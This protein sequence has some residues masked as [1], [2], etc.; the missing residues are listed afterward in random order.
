MGMSEA[1]AK[2]Q[3]AEPRAYGEGIAGFRLLELVVDRRV[4]IPRPE[5]EGLVEQVLTWAGGRWGK[6][7]GERGKGEAGTV[8]DLGTG[9]GCIALSLATEGRFARIVATDVSE[10]ALAVARLNADRVR[11][12]PMPEFRQGPFFE[13]VVGER[14]DVIVTNPPYIAEPE[15]DGLDRSVRDYEPAVALLSGPDGLA[16]TR[17]I[18]ER[19]A[20]YLAPGG[21]LAMEVDS[22]RAEDSAALARAAGF[23][24]VRL[25]SDVF[26]RLRYLLVR[27]EPA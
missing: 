5:T 26:D 14:F 22:R 13:P 4:L 3:A 8:L 21:L 12:E 27:K 23:A 6:G 15:Y 17:T 19:A 2:Q 24:D 7:K 11:P 1:V 20:P 25:Q 9:S 16:H 10:D 18:L